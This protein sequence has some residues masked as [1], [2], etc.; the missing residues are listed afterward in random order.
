VAN[1]YLSQLRF[2][3]VTGH[4][5][6]RPHERKDFFSQAYLFLRCRW[7]RPPE[8]CL[9]Y[10]DLISWRISCAQTFTE[11]VWNWASDR[12]GATSRKL[13]GNIFQRHFSSNFL[14]ITCVSFC[15]KCNL[16][17]HSR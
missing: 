15:I 3:L 13:L 16:S 14:Q 4:L 5:K 9:F 12:P 2:L 11:W 17:S 6:S 1:F 10:C 7:V 8:P